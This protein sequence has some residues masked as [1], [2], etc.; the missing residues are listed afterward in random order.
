[1]MCV[2]VCVGLSVAV[3][4]DFLYSGLSGFNAALGCMAIGGLYFTFSWTTHLY[5][6]AN[7]DARYIDSDL[8]V[9]KMYI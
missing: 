4:R 7:G 9:S 3:H 1:M 8:R 2:C 6:V 5:A